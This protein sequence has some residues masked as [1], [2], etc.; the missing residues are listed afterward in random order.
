VVPL[1]ACLAASAARDRG[2][3]TFF[4]DLAFEK[5]PGKALRKALGRLGVD[6]VGVSIRNIDNTS[7]SSPEFYLPRIRD[8]IVGPALAQLP[9]RV[10]LGGAGFSTLPEEIL[11]F[12]GAP[13]GVVG[14][15]EETFPAVLER[16]RDGGGLE[17]L[18]GI[19]RLTDSGAVREA[20]AVP[21]GMEALPAADIA[22]WV[23]LKR[24]AAYE[25]WAN[26]QT[27]RGCP[28]N[29][30]YCVYNRVEGK[31]YRFRPPASVR[32]EL[33]ALEAAGA[34]HAEFIDST[35]NVPL[36]HA[37]AVLREIADHRVGMQLHAA[38]LNPLEAD[39][40]L[41]DLMKSSGFATAMISAESASDEALKGL[42]K[43]YG[44]EAVRNILKLSESAGFDTF[45]YFLFGG[46]GET[47]ET[48]DE[49]FRFLHE[50]VPPHHLVFVGAGIRV[51]KGA[52]VE[53]VAREQG[54]LS[55]EDKL[56]EPK[57]YFSPDLS[58]ETLLDRIEAEVVAHPNYIQVMDYQNTRAPLM[59]A[60]LLGWIRYKRP[61]WTLVPAL[62]RLFAK[63][64]RKR[65]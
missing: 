60:R 55:P 64:G 16:W 32:E 21:P 26:V 30:T 31:A 41:F 47:R 49:T 44:K 17:G 19:V 11:E 22:T 14:D 51:Q 15:A 62:N 46:P 43:G 52:P 57:F 65:R 40:E 50:E 54:V 25:G 37:K 27:K 39:A 2:F 56:L 18:P 59:L 33:R 12:M 20:G 45:W 34:R 42:N 38:S 53:T 63:F 24:Y 8:E 1:G 9:G 3:D 61:T 58:R 5:N 13:V 48:A 10:V 6:A 23:D 28:L 4:L 7:F 29:C 35:F 36:H